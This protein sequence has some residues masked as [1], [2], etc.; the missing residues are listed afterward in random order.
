MN[1]VEI[2]DRKATWAKSVST[3]IAAAAPVSTKAALE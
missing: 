3:V 2:Q 1:R